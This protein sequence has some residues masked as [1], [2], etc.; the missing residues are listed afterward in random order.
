MGR[1]GGGGGRI[2]LLPERHLPGRHHDFHRPGLPC[3]A[4]GSHGVGPPGLLEGHPELRGECGHREPPRALPPPAP[5]HGAAAGSDRPL[6]QTWWRP[7]SEIA[8]TN[9]ARR[10]LLAD[11]L[12]GTGGPMAHADGGATMA[13]RVGNKRSG[14]GSDVVEARRPTCVDPRRATDAA[15][16]GSDVAGA[17]RPACVETGETRVDITEATNVD[18]GSTTQGD[19]RRLHLAASSSQGSTAA[20]APGPISRPLRACST[21]ADYKRRRTRGKSTPPAQ[22]VPCGL[23]Q[24]IYSSSTTCTRRSS[25]G[26]PA[27]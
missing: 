17:S 5:D 18:A 9:Q 24:P 3:A 1:G 10:R 2:T 25:P 13:A 22:I 20:A 12:T 21:V 6:G 16:P 26:G 14:P 23:G 7:T 11:L 19:S 8:T 15:V 27:G 4:R